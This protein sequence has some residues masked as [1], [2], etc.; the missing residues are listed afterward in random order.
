MKA[1]VLDTNFLVYC[2][3]FRIDLFSE[4]QR[5]CNFKYKICILDSTIKELE[6][7]KPKELSLIK[8]YI[9]KIEVINAKKENVDE[10]L[11]DLSKKDCIIATQDLA[12]KKQLKE[13][14]IIIRQKRYLELKNH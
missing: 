3:K 5:I 9:E 2:V 10:E 4:I 7:I 8:K 13:A 6:K 12:L 14:V 11:I 1:I